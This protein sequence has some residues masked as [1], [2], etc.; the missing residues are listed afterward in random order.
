MICFIPAAQ[1]RVKVS[2]FA[3]VVQDIPVDSFMSHAQF[4]LFR[5]PTTYL[6]CAPV[7]TVQKHNLSPKLNR[8]T[9][10]K[11]FFLPLHSKLMGL[12]GTKPRIST[13]TFHFALDAKFMPPYVVA[14]FS[15]VMS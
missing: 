9:L 2:F 14:D 13:I 4:F 7:A 5:K 10:M 6:F 12:L 11:L 3:F 15:L 1:L 8:K